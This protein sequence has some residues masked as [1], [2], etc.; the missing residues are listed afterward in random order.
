MRNPAQQARHL[1]KQAIE[2]GQLD[3]AA[4][5]ILLERAAKLWEQSGDEISAERARQAAYWLQRN[6][7]ER[8][9]IS[10]GA[11]TP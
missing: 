1:Y 11:Q 2:A 6:R 8:A 3:T 7:A 5:G 10:T 4:A 9:A